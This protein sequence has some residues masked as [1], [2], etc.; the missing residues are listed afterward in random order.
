LGRVRDELARGA[1]VE[2]QPLPSWGARIRLYRPGLGF[3]SEFTQVTYD[4]ANAAR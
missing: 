4:F 2:V 1:L 3:R